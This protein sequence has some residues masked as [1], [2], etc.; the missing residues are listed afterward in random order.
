MDSWI[1]YVSEYRVGFERGEREV[2]IYIKRERFPS[3]QHKCTV[4]YACHTSNSHRQG[5][6]KRQI[7]RD[8]QSRTNREKKRQK[9]AYAVNLIISLHVRVS[10]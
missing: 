9:L 5:Q 6:T 7:R 8:G 2:Y 10:K 3:H 1:I 4:E